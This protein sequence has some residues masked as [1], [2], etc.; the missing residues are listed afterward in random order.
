MSASIRVALRVRPENE[1]TESVH[2]S[3]SVANAMQ[4]VSVSD[5]NA[6]TLRK[7][8]DNGMSD[9]THQYSFDKVF[10]ADSTQE[11]VF[12]NV[13]DLIDESLKGFNVTIFGT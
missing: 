3:S 6:V 7:H 9:L 10:E 2:E 11:E 5:G 1:S 4:S 13:R 12:S 8:R